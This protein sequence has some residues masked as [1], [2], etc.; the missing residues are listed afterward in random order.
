MPRWHLLQGG[1]WQVG[2]G[3]Y[4]HISTSFIARHLREN[5]LRN[6]IIFHFPRW[7]GIILGTQGGILMIYACFS[8]ILGQIWSILPPQ[9]TLNTLKLLSCSHVCE[10]GS[11]SI[12]TNWGWIWIIWV[13]HCCL[14]LDFFD[15]LSSPKGLSRFFWVQTTKNA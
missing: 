1:H 14:L 6:W 11:V 15:L 8:A 13:T 4:H 7:K 3:N 12:Q 5:K 9:I 2:Q 10:L